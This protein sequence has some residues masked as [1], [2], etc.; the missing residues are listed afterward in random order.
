MMP[1]AVEVRGLRKVFVGEGGESVAALADVNLEFAPGSFTTIIGPTGCGKTTLLRIIAGLEKPTAGEVV[2]SGEVVTRP[3]RDVGMVFQHYSLFPWR[4]AADNI[5]FGLELDGTPPQRRRERVRALLELVG[6]TEFARLRP[7][8]LS[9]GMQQRV[10]IARALAT[11][12]QVLLLDEPFG[13]LDER[14]RHRLGE[15][16]LNIWQKTKKTV[17]FVTHNIDEAIYLGERVVVM[18]DQPG[19]VIATVPVQLSRPRDRLAVEFGR[20]LL[21]V[22]GLLGQAMAERVE[23]TETRKGG[24]DEKTHRRYDCGC[25]AR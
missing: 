5:G 9:G 23:L 20:T 22:R 3:R 13:S 18:V 19:R 1:G 16:L 25:G 21:E 15:E 7:Y 14:T 11:N 12:P 10:A 17:I 6:L 2:V 24:K 4:N 8:E